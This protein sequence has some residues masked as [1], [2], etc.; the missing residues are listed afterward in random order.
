[1]EDNDS[2]ED[3]E[4]VRESDEDE[5]NEAD[6]SVRDSKLEEPEFKL[7]SGDE[8]IEGDAELISEASRNNQVKDPVELEREEENSSRNPSKDF[9][10]EHKFEVEDERFALTSAESNSEE[11]NSK[12]ASEDEDIDSDGRFE[13]ASET[14]GSDADLFIV[15]SRNN[16]VKDI[17]EL[18]REEVIDCE[19]N[20]LF[21]PSD[22]EDERQEHEWKD[23]ALDESFS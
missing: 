21:N 18:D 23:S 11:T 2:E 15:D 9:G 13:R 16:Q 14:E 22:I 8:E 4:K 17:V 10:D 5:S 3:V 1:M 6:D 7:Y 19:E 12:L 20:N